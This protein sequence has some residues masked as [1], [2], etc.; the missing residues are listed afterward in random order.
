CNIL[1]PKERNPAIATVLR[2]HTFYSEIALDP[3]TPQYQDRMA[4]ARQWIEI[5]QDGDNK[6]RV[7]DIEGAQSIFDNKIEGGSYK[8]LLGQDLRNKMIAAKDGVYGGN[9]WFFKN[10]AAAWDNGAFDMNWAP[11]TPPPRRY[12]ANNKELAALDGAISKYNDD[13][14]T[15]ILDV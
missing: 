10:L 8:W 13:L 15:K 4:Q 12:D 9:W 5:G 14:K 2:E 3:A 7:K 11:G 6:G 1:V